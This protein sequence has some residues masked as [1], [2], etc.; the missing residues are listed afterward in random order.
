MKR[1]VK[2]GEDIDWSTGYSDFFHGRK[3]EEVPY[4]P[5]EEPQRQ[6]RWR[7]GWDQAQ[8]DSKR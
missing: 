5:N 8:R 7:N 2:A 6:N 3:R 1:D 4:K